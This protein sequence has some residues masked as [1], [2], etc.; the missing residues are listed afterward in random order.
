MQLMLSHRK[1]ITVILNAPKFLYKIPFSTLMAD[2]NHIL[3]SL[4]WI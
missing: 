2:K 1:E 4:F 3:V